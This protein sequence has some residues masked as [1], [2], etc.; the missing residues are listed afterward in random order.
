MSKALAKRGRRGLAKSNPLS[1]PHWAWLLG[2]AAVGAV[3][4]GVWSATQSTTVPVGAKNAA[5]GAGGGLVLGGLVGSIAKKDIGTAV[6]GA[7]GG[8]LILGTLWL[9]TSTPGTTSA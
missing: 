6:A 3:A 2:G 5:V 9:T 8:G 7:I 4:A 1:R